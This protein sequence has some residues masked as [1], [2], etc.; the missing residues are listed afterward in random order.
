L[1]IIDTVLVP[2]LVGLLTN[3]GLLRLHVHRQQAYRGRS[4][5]H[6]EC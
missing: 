5:P 6:N 1:A 4:E 3:I 2:G